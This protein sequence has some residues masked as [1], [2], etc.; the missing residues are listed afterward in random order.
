ML[1]PWR[2][3]ADVIVVFVAVLLVNFRFDK[4]NILK[5]RLFV[6]VN[7]EDIDLTRRYAF[8]LYTITRDFQ[9]V[10]GDTP[11]HI[12]VLTGNK[13]LIATLL[14][15]Y[16]GLIDIENNAGLTPVKLAA[17]DKEMLSLIIDIFNICKAHE[18]SKSKK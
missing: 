3:D 6:A 13:E 7:E 4:I 9:N 12:A 2:R 14:S 17:G 1:L 11:L 15:V 8:E 18:E 5:E 16:P 10:T